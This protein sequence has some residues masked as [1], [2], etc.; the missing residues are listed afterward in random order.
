MARQGDYLLESGKLNEARDSYKKALDAI[1]KST[2]SEEFKNNAR[3][4]HLITEVET[5]V[6]MKDFARAKTNAEQ[7]QKNAEANHHPIQMQTAHELAGIIALNEQKYDA[8]LSELKKANDRNPRNLYRI[9]EAY[10]GLG[11]REKA[12]EA[13]M[14]TAN[15]NEI[16][17]DLAFVRA[18]ARQQ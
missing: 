17:Y 7:Y 2:L 4:A 14:R 10:A 6:R 18:K 12:K 16:N 1:E 5:A 3:Q 8:A 11:D 9:G 15:F 13:W